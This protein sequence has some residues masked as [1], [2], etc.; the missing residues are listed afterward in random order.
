MAALVG[1]NDHG[2]H[3][4]LYLSDPDGNGLELYWDRP[5]DEWPLD[6]MGHLVFG[7]GRLDVDGLLVDGEDYR[8]D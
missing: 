2:T 3:E 5:E 4:A 1:V 6:E 8:K 7:G